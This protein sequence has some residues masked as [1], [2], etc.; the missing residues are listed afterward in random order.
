M[1]EHP[2]AGALKWFHSHY[3]LISVRGNPSAVR[4]GWR[5]SLPRASDKDMKPDNHAKANPQ[6]TALFE[7]RL[8]DPF[9]YLGLHREFGRP[10]FRAYFPQAGR[11]WLWVND[12]WR[13][14]VNEE[15]LFLWH[16]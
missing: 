16:G 4:P 15:G 9:A 12:D 1:V 11:A 7:A 6:R 2:R 10:V 5:G 8:H 13:E 3:L 14:M